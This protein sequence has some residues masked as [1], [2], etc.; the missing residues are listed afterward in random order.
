MDTVRSR[1][2]D[3]LMTIGTSP[4][5]ALFEMSFSPGLIS[6]AGGDPASELFDVEGMGRAFAAVMATQGARA[7]QYASTDGEPEM[8]AAA[9]TRSTELGVPTT[10]DQVLMTSGSQQGLGLLAQT[11]INP[12]DVVLVENP[13]YVS[14]IQAFALQGAEFQ[15]VDTDEAG[16][17]PEALDAAIRRWR[18]KAVYLIPTFQNP[19]GIT[20]TPERRRQVAD[21]LA[22]HD[23]WLIE[24]DPYSEL[25]Y[26]DRREIPLAADPRLD[27]RSFL[28]NTLSKVLSPGLRVGW[29]RGP[30][31][32]LERLSIAKQATALQSSTVDQLAAVEYLARTDLQAKLDVIR[33][34]YAAR[35]DTLL[36]GLGELLPEGSAMTHPRGGMFIW[37]RLPEGW[38]AS[39]LV[40]DAI[41]AGAMFVPGAPFYV[42]DPDPRTLRFSFVSNGV[43]RTQEGLARMAGVFSRG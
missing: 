38:N 35:R 2:N 8:K 27:D 26:S 23:T 3:H 10:P 18:P 32:I 39:E 5:R 33:A 7:M 37:A 4:I 17:V 28:L 20:M 22:E 1:L 40:Y 31:A 43:E 16:A 41:E 6:F 14:A 15:A 21:V 34:E 9:A 42:T 11:L 19:T 12:G 25:Y 29:V 13:T 24:D 36:H 30:A